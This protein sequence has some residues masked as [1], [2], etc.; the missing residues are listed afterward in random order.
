MCPYKVDAK[1]R[2]NPAANHTTYQA[3]NNIYHNPHRSQENPI[4]KIEVF[5]VKIAIEKY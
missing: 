4:V 5:Y 3:K 2:N 1:N